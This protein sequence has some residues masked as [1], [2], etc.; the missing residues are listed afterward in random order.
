[1]KELRL[2][3]RAAL[4]A[5]TSAA[6]LAGQSTPGRSRPQLLRRPYQPADGTSER[7]YYV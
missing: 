4:L 1:M 6:A 7:E 2:T 5:G 3:R